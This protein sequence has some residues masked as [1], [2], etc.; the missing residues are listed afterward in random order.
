MQSVKRPSRSVSES[1]VFEGVHSGPKELGSRTGY[2]TSGESSSTPIRSD[3]GYPCNFKGYIGVQEER[4]ADRGADRKL[5][6]QAT[7]REE[8]EVY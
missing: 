6:R 1:V 3:K 2:S 7:L 5:H 8:V 4:S